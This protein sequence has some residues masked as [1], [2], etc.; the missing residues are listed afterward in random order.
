MRFNQSFILKFVSNV[1]SFFKI[2]LFSFVLIYFMLNS[3]RVRS[4]DDVSLKNDF[5]G[6]PHDC[7]DNVQ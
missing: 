2:K 3:C 5:G 4:M 1:Y 6:C 7:P